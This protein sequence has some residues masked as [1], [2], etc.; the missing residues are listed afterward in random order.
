[1]VELKN[2]KLLVVSPHPDDE[3]IGC[4]GLIQKIKQSGGAVYVLFL[5]VG[6]TQDFNHH[7]VSTQ[8][9]RLQEIE[10]VSRFLEFNDWRI[11]FPG[12]DHHLRLDQIDQKK[13]VHEIE[14]GDRIS[15]EAIKPDILVFPDFTDYNQD[16]LA[17]AQATYIACRP[18]LNTDKFIPPFILS[19]K[20][21]MNLWSLQ[22]PG[23]VNFLVGL[24]PEIVERK[25]QALNLYA[26]QTRSDGHLRSN[27]TLKA[28]AILHGSLDGKLF[29]EGFYSH[30][31][32]S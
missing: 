4:G 30:K 27:R 31:L 16:H 2:K 19:Y 17:A 12:N 8:D 32:I 20:T 25:L 11:A 1:M 15:L 29:A 3:V 5:T 28:L 21:P 13:I 26:T 9:E 14:R 10:A 22:E 6:T 18:A 23:R 24:T 7:G